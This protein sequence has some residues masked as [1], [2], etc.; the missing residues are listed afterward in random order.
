MI[1]ALAVT[2]YSSRAADATV[3]KLDGRFDTTIKPFLQ[4]YCVTCHGG[5]N[6]AAD[7]DLN[8]YSSLSAVVNDGRRW[9]LV[10]SR[11]KSAEMPPPKEADKFPKPA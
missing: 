11:I 10:L 5:D 9:D 1:L 3:T 2:S 4:T 8:S 6:P 7:L